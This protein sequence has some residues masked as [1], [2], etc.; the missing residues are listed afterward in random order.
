VEEE[1]RRDIGNAP[2]VWLVASEEEMWDQRRLVRQWLEAWG[3]VTEQQGFARVEVVRY[4]I[5]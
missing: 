4:A 3:E 5:Q 1:M 2:A